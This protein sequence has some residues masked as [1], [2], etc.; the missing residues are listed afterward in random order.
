M[1]KLF[2]YLLMA[3]KM[4]K[5][6]TTGGTMLISMFVYSFVFGWR[7][8]VGVVLLILVHEMGHYVAA[9]QKG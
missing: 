1:G 9:R 2:A 6:L 4:G 5:L 7:Y 3:G 8:A